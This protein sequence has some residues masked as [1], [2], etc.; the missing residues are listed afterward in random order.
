M[1]LTSPTILRLQA[2]LAAGALLLGCFLLGLLVTPCLAVSGQLGDLNG[3]GVIDV[4]D[5][6]LLQN[7]LT[8]VS[9]LASN[10]LPLADLN[11][12]GYLTQADVDT[13]ANLILG[14]SPTNA[15]RPVTLDPA[16]GSSQVGVTVRPKAMFP[17][18]IDTSTLNSN[19]FYAS[20]LGQKLPAT[21]V[22]SSDGTWAWLF[23]NPSM[24]NAAQVQVTVDGSSIRTRLG[25]QVD[26]AGTGTPGG[27]ATFNFSTVSVAP[28]GNTWLVGRVVDP[29]PDLVPRTA[30][31]FVADPSGD[32]KLGH[33][34]IP[35]RGVKVYILGLETNVVYTDANGLF[36]LNPVPVGDVKISVDGRT[37]TSPPSGYYFP[38]MVMDATFQPG[39]M[40]HLMI[41]ND[42][43]YLPRVASNILQTV[44]WTSNTLVTLRSNAAYTLSPTQ[45]QYLTI[46]IP[47]NSLI[48]MNGQ[49]MSSGQVGISVVPP[50]LVKD[51]LP[52]GL[53]QHTFDITVQ[54]PGV[55][56]FTT[57]AQ[58]TFPNVF[59]TNA[60]PGS[61]LNFLSF[62]HTT[63]RLVIEGTGTVSAD[64]LYVTTDP[65]TGVTHPGWHGL[66]P[67]GIMLD[68]KTGKPCLA[69]GK[70]GQ[71]V[72]AAQD[73]ATA[74]FDALSAKDGFGHVLG[75]LGSPYG[76]G[77]GLIDDG[78]GCLTKHGWDEAKSCATEVANVLLI[79]TPEGEIKTL[80][81]FILAG[82]SAINAASEFA[83]AAAKFRALASLPACN[84]ADNAAANAEAAQL[85]DQLDGVPNKAAQNIPPLTQ[86]QNDGQ[87]INSF[88]SIINPSLP[89]LGLTQAQYDQ[90]LNCLEDYLA[91]TGQ[92]DLE[93]FFLTDLLLII[94]ELPFL[95]EKYLDTHS[96]QDIVGG[97]PV[98][99]SAEF[100][101]NVLRGRAA[102]ANSIQV[103]TPPNTLVR[104]RVYDP[105]SRQISVAVVLTG[106]SGASMAPLLL[107]SPDSGPDHDGDGLSDAAEVIIGSDTNKWSTAGDGI[108]DGAKVAQCIDPVA[109]TP[110]ATGLIASLPLLG[111]AKDVTIAGSVT[112][113]S[114]QTAYLACGSRGL[115]IVN[116]AQFQAP[117]LLGQ[118]DLPGDASSV[119]VDPTVQVAAVAANSGGLHLIDVSSAAQPRLILTISAN[120]SAVKVVAGVA[121]AA[122]GNT[123][124]AY[125]L[126]S[127]QLLQSL[128][129]GGNTL[130][131]LSS[132]GFFLYTMDTA[133]TLRVIDLSSGV[134]TARGSLTLPFGGGGLFV[135]DNI[136]YVSAA[137]DTYGG[138]LTVSTANPDQPV[139]L[140]NSSASPT[141][142][143][144]GPTVVVNGSG[145]G[146]VAV[147]GGRG[148]LPSLQ[149][150][151]VSNPTNTGA[152]ITTYNLPAAPYNLAIGGGIAF[153]ADGTAGLQVLNYKSLDTFGVPPAITLSNSFTMTTPTNGIALE[154][155]LV[156]VLAVTSDDVQVWN[157]EFYIDGALALSDQSFPFEYL[158]V[159]PALTANKTNFTLQARAFDTGGNATW[160]PSVTVQLT[161]DTSPPLV[162]RIYPA[163]T[164]ILEVN[165]AVY[166]YFNKPLN[167]SVLNAASLALQYAGPDSKLDT[168]DDV[169]MTNGVVSYV[170]NSKAI[171]LTF[172]AKLPEGLYR[173]ALG[174]NI[175]DAS[176][177]FFT[178]G[179]A[180]TFWNLRGGPDGD[181][182]SDGILNSVEVAYGF[183]PINP[184]TDGDGWDDGVEFAEG[185]SYVTNSA[186]RP[187]LTFTTRPPVTANLPGPAELGLPGTATTI[188]RPPVLVT[189]PGNDEMGLVGRPLALARPPILV[190]VPGPSEL[191]NIG[192]SLSLAR[193]PLLVTLPANAELGAV[194]SNLVLAQPPLRVSL[195]NAQPSA[196]PAP[197]TA[198]VKPTSKVSYPAQ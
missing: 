168:A 107:T 67:P 147:A 31:D 176:G 195:T 59:G 129:P 95:F 116:A 57:P 91:S 156:R 155:N 124:Q 92:L 104:L 53:L 196:V 190:T 109:G 34:L 65:G 119:S 181:S 159:T 162:R 96:S 123:I 48:G 79:W 126:L 18:P 198:F 133:N 130:T 75:N 188:A 5:L 146:L 127:G 177:N 132:E 24:P 29:G 58:M 160:T 9:L 71:A 121:Y 114:Q 122:V 41:D 154:G 54:A 103:F 40:N 170:A 100:E 3:D 30:D 45:Q 138:F 179:L 8:G 113:P 68:P 86:M 62:D 83:D 99:W 161:P 78:V 23:F 105:A 44:S 118:I 148:V 164:N 80:G 72:A 172:P 20:Y 70:F 193:P 28:L 106:A 178:N 152:F 191:G 6:V 1:A 131:G 81:E 17:K 61:K 144:P 157:V 165:N 115:S 185:A 26:A 143:S 137:N 167:F 183:N 171:A 175:T 33:Y 149:I 97:C 43:L 37:A 192:S 47:A 117:V 182:D 39:A 134:M 112:D 52:A 82:Q 197:P 55:A 90:F 51:M 153:I 194:G 74:I 77:V 46:T 11:D 93:G 64:G 139:L 150:Y 89:H 151:N 187:R 7:H 94:Y 135:G 184:D 88:G 25:L 38:E 128:T 69:D 98:F 108:S 36:S 10:T 63:G 66:T 19:N 50:D 49:P 102:S 120:A 60:A 136:A 142:A 35:I 87:C 73:A 76:T 173:A 180:W 22:P 32:P 141:S 14:Q 169:M 186:L 145:L 42:T 125:D 4:R 16:N 101:G 56:T 13:L 2:S 110:L 21:I 158:F 15:P 189:L 140:G 84:P 12:D 174:T 85:A 163:A 166:G 27:V 111:E